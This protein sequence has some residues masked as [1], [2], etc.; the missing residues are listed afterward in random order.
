MHSQLSRLIL[1]PKILC[2]V[3]QKKSF[4]IIYHGFYGLTMVNYYYILQPD[5]KGQ[6]VKGGRLPFL[7]IYDHC[8]LVR[9]KDVK[10]NTKLR[11]NDNDKSKQTE[12]RRLL[13]ELWPN[14]SLRYVPKILHIGTGGP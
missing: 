9:E 8:R 12:I 2:K 10:G 4:V 1:S 5:S 11:W 3:L 13:I 14:L 6:K 7:L